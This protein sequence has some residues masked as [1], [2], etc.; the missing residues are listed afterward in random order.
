[1]GEETSPQVLGGE[2]WEGGRLSGG[3]GRNTVP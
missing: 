2:A 1:M 3:G